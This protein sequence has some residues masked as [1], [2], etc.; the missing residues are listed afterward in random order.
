M[1]D[2]QRADIPYVVRPMRLAD[3]EEVMMIERA[4]FSSPW[5]ASAFCYD[6]TANENAHYWVVVPNWPKDAKPEPSRSWWRRLWHEE[7]KERLSIVGYAG[8]WSLI[9]EAH[10]GT[11]AVAPAWRGRGLGEL[12]LVNLLDQAV[13]LGLRVATLEVRVSNKVAQ[14]LYRKYGFEI[15]GRRRGYYSDNHEDAWIMS[16]GTLT[17]ATFQRNLYQLKQAL[18]ERLKAQRPPEE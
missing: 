18:F 5:P 16:T 11:I 9:D 10:I 3:V 12:L 1:S 2:I 15:V 7:P 8:F 17:S 13:A 4:S 14:N 6:L